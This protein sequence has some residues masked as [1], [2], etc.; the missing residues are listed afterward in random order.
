MLLLDV[1]LL[2]CGGLLRVQRV[3]AWDLIAVFV[4]VVLV[5]EVLIV[6][7]YCLDG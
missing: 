4:H 2:V 5:D 7:V 1:M 6:G 3:S